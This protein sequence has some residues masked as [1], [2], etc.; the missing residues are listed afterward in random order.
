MPGPSVRRRVE[1]PWGGIEGGGVRAT[2][3]DLPGFRLPWP[4]TPL[5]DGAPSGLES[6]ATGKHGPTRYPNFSFNVSLAHA[7]LRSVWCWAIPTTL[8]VAECADLSP[9]TG[10]QVRTSRRTS[11]GASCPA[12]VVVRTAFAPPYQTPPSL[13]GGPSARASPPGTRPGPFRALVQPPVDGRHYPC[14]ARSCCRAPKT[15]GVTQ[16]E[17]CNTRSK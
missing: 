1:A 3:F 15:S 13:K 5:A 9:A 14:T 11:R 17:Q 16:G 8:R 2:A 6:R 4:R 12:G 10:A 7:C